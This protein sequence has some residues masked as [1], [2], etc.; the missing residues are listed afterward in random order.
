MTNLNKPTN[1]D[2]TNTRNIVSIGD[3]S[4]ELFGFILD[5]DS[6]EEIL[7]YLANQLYLRGIVVAE[8][9]DAVLARE[10]EFPTGLPTE[11][12][13]VAIP[14]SDRMY[15]HRSA[16]TVAKLNQQVIFNNMGAPEE[17]LQVNLIF[18]LAVPKGGEIVFMIQSLVE[19]FQD[20]NVLT[21]LINSKSEHEL[22]EIVKKSINDHLSR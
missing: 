2:Q 6:K 22:V 17:E 8:Y 15:V 13:A 19:L 9:G 7:R 3:D 14:H 18:L 4:Y 21:R 12:I 20:G 5:L 1:T 10:K 16:I 11:P